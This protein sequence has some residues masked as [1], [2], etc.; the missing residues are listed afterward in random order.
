MA[1]TLNPWN[2][3]VQLTSLKALLI[4][5][6][7]ISSLKKLRLKKMQYLLWSLLVGVVPCGL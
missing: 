7:S 3:D 4:L 1:F 6:Q 5:S 2:L